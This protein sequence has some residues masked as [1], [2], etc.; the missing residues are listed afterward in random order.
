VHRRGST[1]WILALLPLCW[2]VGAIAAGVDD[3][4]QKLAGPSSRTWVYKR[5]VSHMGATSDCV[6][7]ETYTFKA[8]NQLVVSVCKDGRM[9][10]TTYRW[11]LS[12]SGSG[13]VVVN[14]AGMGTYVVLF[15][16]PAEGGHMM[17][18]RKKN[19]PQTDPVTDKE[20]S[21]SED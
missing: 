20:F 7:G 6:S 19:G 17:R 14:I 18:L 4:E 10:D 1:R 9:V 8:T 3:F 16:D 21:L 5:V 2:S 15:K 13:D 11:S 12:D